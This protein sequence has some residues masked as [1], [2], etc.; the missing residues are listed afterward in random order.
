MA[1]QYIDM[2]TIKFQLFN[3][4]ELESILSSKYYGHHDLESMS[5]FLESIK[6]FSDQDLY[7]CFREMDEQPA[8][9]KEGKIIAHP[10]VSTI[11]KKGENWGL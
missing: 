3:L 4:H 6:D 7:P 10:A 11:M 8:H 9:Y 5:L 1:K 2:K